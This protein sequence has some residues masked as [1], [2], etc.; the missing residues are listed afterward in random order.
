LAEARLVAIGRRQVQQ[1]GGRRPFTQ[2]REWLDH[3]PATDMLAI[4][5]PGRDLRFE[6]A[7]IAKRLDGE[8]GATFPDRA[9]VNLDVQ[10]DI[11]FFAAVRRQSLGD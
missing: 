1:I 7:A 2:L 11:A 6:A 8:Q 3:L 4:V 5:Q 9:A 10:R